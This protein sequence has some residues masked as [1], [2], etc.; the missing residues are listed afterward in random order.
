[1]EIIYLLIPIAMLFVVLAIAL[2]FWAVR[3]EQYADLDRAGDV[4]LFDD[5]PP[6]SPSKP[7]TLAAKPAVTAQTLPRAQP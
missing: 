4:I 6:A 2:F 1:M 5:V 7:H 3:S